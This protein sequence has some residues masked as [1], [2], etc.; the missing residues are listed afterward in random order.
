[1]G[2]NPHLLL[3]I[4]RE[5]R[6]LSDVESMEVNDGLPRAGAARPGAAL[7]QWLEPSN[8]V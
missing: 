4:R 6:L 1:M 7:N 5:L 8:A 2:S 3:A